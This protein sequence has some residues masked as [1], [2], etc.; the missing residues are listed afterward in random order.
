MEATQTTKLKHVDYRY[1][2]LPQSDEA[3]VTRHGPEQ[4]HLFIIMNSV[5]TTQSNIYKQ[6]AYRSYA[7]NPQTRQKGTISNT[8][9]NL[10][11]QHHF[12]LLY[13]LIYKTTASK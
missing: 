6:K 4:N 7:Q 12:P 2:Y 8:T 9:I 11:E 5:H 13:L 1:V 10:Q 3:K